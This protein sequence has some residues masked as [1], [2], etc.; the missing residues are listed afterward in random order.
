MTTTSMFNSNS[1]KST[2]DESSDHR[3]KA[4]DLNKRLISTSA[5]TKILPAMRPTTPKETTS[6]SV[7]TKA[8]NPND[9]VE[10]VLT[11]SPSSSSE[12]MDEDDERDDRINLDDSES[13]LF[14]KKKKKSSRHSSTKHKRDTGVIVGAQRNSSELLNGS[15][16]NVSKKEIKMSTSSTNIEHHH[17]PTKFNSNDQSS[18][19]ASRA[20]APTATTGS[21]DRPPGRLNYYDSESNTFSEGLTRAN[22]NGHLRNRTEIESRRRKSNGIFNST[23]NYFVAF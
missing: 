6:G 10:D 12:N 8:K 11:P 18:K 17:Q 20:D 22:S 15:R 1:S 13:S 4:N 19:M 5:A 23:N 14:K 7:T 9:I 16:D 2:T 21:M 3:F